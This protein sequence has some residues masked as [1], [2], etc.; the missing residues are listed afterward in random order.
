[1]TCIPK[2]TFLRIVTAFPTLCRSDHSALSLSLDFLCSLS[3]RFGVSVLVGLRPFEG[4]D[5]RTTYSR[6]MYD[7]R[8]STDLMVLLQRR[9]SPAL[10]SRPL[11]SLSISRGEI[12]D[13]CIYKAIDRRTA[14]MTYM[15]RHDGSHL[16]PK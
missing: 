11:F 13:I 8:E 10:P 14:A 1:M 2:S 3:W 6:A 15:N 12:W 16:D 5:Y 9:S 7:H 4:S